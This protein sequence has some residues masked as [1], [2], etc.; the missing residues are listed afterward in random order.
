MNRAVQAAVGIFVLVIGA[1]SLSTFYTV[2]QAEQVL[3]LQFGKPVRVVKEPGL[4]VKIP[5]MQDI[6]R[7]DRRLLDF[8]AEAQEVI[9]SDQKRMVVDAFARY[10][11]VDPLL[12]YQ[13]VGNETNM[14]A[15]LGAI[16]NA[17]LRNTLGQ[18]P[19]AM[20]L[21][22]RR[23]E[24]MRHMSELVINEA[25]PFGIEVLD[26]R[27]MRADLHPD[28]SP[29]IYARMQTERELVA[30]QERA[31]G[32]ETAQRI[33]AEAERDRTVLLAEA[34]R[35]SSVLRGQGDG[36]A[37]RIFADAYNKDP[38]FYAFYRSLQAYR[39]ALADG[40][41]TMVLSP[42]SDFFRFFRE[43]RGSE[44]GSAHPTPPRQ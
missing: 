5:F 31:E 18:V 44:G 34:Q 39:R 36:D 37:T 25:K 15:R 23:S 6:T 30:R 17:S 43:L 19:F 27:I 8:D 42:D 24:L 22:A 32:S 33:R 35:Q 4:K 1:V 28:N 9:M 29:A 41:S 38:G 2:H 16:V 14:R 26:V 12:F 13:S 40:S 21:T 20:V 10:R 11:I 3:V 7:F